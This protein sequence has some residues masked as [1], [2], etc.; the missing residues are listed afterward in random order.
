LFTRRP[1][2]P[3]QIL[4][5]GV[6]PGAPASDAATLRS[7]I[8]TAAAELVAR[9]GVGPFELRVGYGIPPSS[10]LSDMSALPTSRTSVA[11]L[12]GRKKDPEFT[13]VEPSYRMDQLALPEHTL[14]RLLDCIAFVDLA[15][16][17]FDKWGLRGI[18]PHPS[19]AVNLRG[20]PG[21]G[22]TMAAHAAAHHL[23]KKIMLSRLSELESKFHGQ[24][25]KNLVGLFES[26]KTQDAVLFIDEAE[27]LLSR[28]FAQPEQAAE[29]AINSMRT[30]LLMA[31]DAFDGLVIF[32]SNLP[33]SYDAAV[34]SR[35]M[36]VDFELPDRDARVRIWRTHLP[37]ALPVTADVTAE[38]L[39]EID[40]V[41]GRDIKLAVISAAVGAARRDLPEIA[42]DLLLGALEQQRKEA[43]PAR[44]APADPALKKK[45]V[46]AMGSRPPTE[47]LETLD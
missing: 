32:A 29:S 16:V 10:T 9:H 18:E 26:A 5:E 25:P 2:S 11:E 30:E 47:P 37:D 39:A 28:R 12:S 33:H 36:H 21:T 19:I 6:I 46:R 38:R 44:T 31:L 20:P 1:A 7:R 17:V 40:G 14:D 45:I 27:S 22:K 24:G 13:A 43:A 34:E 15:P 23:K 3:P 4:V 35:L 8:H 42:L 41:S